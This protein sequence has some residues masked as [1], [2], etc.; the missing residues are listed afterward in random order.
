MNQSINSLGAMPPGF[1]M[2]TLMDAWD[3]DELAKV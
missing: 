2:Q 1:E 3:D